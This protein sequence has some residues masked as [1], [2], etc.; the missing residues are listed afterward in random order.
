MIV[1]ELIAKLQKQPPTAKVVYSYY[2]NPE[3]SVAAIEEVSDVTF[4]KDGFYPMDGEP[5]VEL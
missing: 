5:L 1:S 3:D 4:W 2:A